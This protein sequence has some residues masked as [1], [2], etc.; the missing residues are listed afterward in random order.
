[1]TRDASST[2]ARF[3]IVGRVRRAHGMQGDLVVEPLTDT[4]DI[5]LAP[6][7]CLIGGTVTGDVSEA[8]VE[9]HV[10]TAAPFQDALLVR[11]D[12]VTG[13]DAAERWHER[14]L[15]VPE[16][17]L[18]AP[19]VGEMYMHDLV[20]L[21]VESEGGEALGSVANVYELP[22]G[23]MLE[24]RRGGGAREFLLPYRE[25]FVRRVDAG[26]RVMVVELPEGFFD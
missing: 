22:Q 12:E 14:Y 19:R 9:L 13:R 11:F 4:P 3:V 23:I 21:R 10:V 2:V 1:V 18:P 7:R 15:L 6:G 8:R 16:D 26:A 5:V 17:E 25:E 24:V 20:G